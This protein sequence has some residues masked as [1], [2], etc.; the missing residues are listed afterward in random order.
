MLRMDTLPPCAH[1]LCVR[2]CA[3]KC[4]NA[5]RAKEK[6]QPSH[7]QGHHEGVPSMLQKANHKHEK[8]QL[9]VILGCWQE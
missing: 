7:L 1:H 5:L 8:R 6:E 3:L 9:H 2:H 4:T